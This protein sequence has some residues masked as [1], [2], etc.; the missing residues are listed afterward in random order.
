M[1]R[2]IYAECRYDECRCAECRYAE[3]RY[4]EYRYAECRYAECRGDSLLA[5]L[6]KY[7]AWMKKVFY[8]LCPRLKTG[9]MQFNWCHDI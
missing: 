4:A 8:K 2:V 3:C 9:I 7:Q 1:L 5:S 6:L